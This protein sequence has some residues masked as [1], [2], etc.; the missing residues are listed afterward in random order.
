VGCQKGIWKAGYLL[1]VHVLRIDSD[2]G[3]APTAQLVLTASWLTVKEVAL[4]A[5][6]LAASLP[7]SSEPKS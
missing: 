5:G 6:T 3:L 4:L 1:F 2:G 7:I